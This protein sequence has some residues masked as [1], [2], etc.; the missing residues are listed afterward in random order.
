MLVCEFDMVL[1]NFVLVCFYVV[2]GF[3]EV[4]M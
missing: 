1:F 4:G 3:C 2:F